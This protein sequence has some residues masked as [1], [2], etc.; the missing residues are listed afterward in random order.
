MTR[1]P[2]PRVGLRPNRKRSGSRDACTSSAGVA[3]SRGCLGDRVERRETHPPE[4][5]GRGPREGPLLFA[6]RDRHFVP[7][8]RWPALP[9]HGEP[10]GRCARMSVCRGSD[11]LQ[12]ARQ[13]RFLPRKS[14]S[15]RQARRGSAIAEGLP[16]R[17]VKGT[18]SYMEARSRH[19]GAA[20]LS[21]FHGHGDVPRFVGEGVWTAPQGHRCADSS[22][23]GW[24]PARVKGPGIGALRGFTSVARATR[25]DGVVPARRHPP[26]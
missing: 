10:R 20:G 1:W 9:C 6:L 8:R 14:L 24:V 5:S 11:C 21:R 26:A 16:A 25:V 23:R 22:Q 18:G 13:R 15:H 12:D 3:E 17:D 7:T 2:A 19:A 4:R